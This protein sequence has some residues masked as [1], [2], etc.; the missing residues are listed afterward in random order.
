M[1]LLSDGNKLT[2]LTLTYRFNVITFRRLRYK[3]YVT[4]IV[5]RTVQGAKGELNSGQ[6]S[7]TSRRQEINNE[8]GTSRVFLHLRLL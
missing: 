4:S 1:M 6:M 2:R 5:P 7:S 8:V 3:I